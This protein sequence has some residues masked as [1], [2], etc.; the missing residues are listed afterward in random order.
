MQRYIGHISCWFPKKSLL[1][2]IENGDG[3]LQAAIA[4]I[5]ADYAENGKLKRWLSVSSP[6]IQ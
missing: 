1:D 6:E 4:A 3:K 5:Q 2:T